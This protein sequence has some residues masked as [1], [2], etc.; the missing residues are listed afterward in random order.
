MFFVVSEAF[1]KGGMKLDGL[2]RSFDDVFY[3][4]ANDKKFGD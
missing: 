1:G 2:G 3:D 4:D